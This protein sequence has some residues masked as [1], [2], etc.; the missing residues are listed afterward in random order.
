MRIL[1][2]R[3]EPFE[4]PGA[5]AQW[6]HRREH[7]LVEHYAHRELLVPSAFDMFVVLG[8]TVSA[9]DDE[10][11]PW[12]ARERDFIANAVTDGKLVLG[13]CLGAQQLARAIGGRVARNP[14]PEVGFYPVS[15]TDA[16]RRTAVFADW[17]D[18]FTAGHWHGDTFFPPER[19]PVI[20]VSQACMRQGFVM[21][22]GRVVGLQFHLEWTENALLRLVEACRDQLVPGPHVMDADRMLAHPELLAEGKELLFGLLDRMEALAADRAARREGEG[23]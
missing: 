11:H 9:N 4:G 3:H 20:A 10:E 16:G 5:I 8:G 15:L 22:H 14:E 13:I 17:P 2:F 7:E 19:A 18:T 12:L 23:A 6:A 21:D 1:V